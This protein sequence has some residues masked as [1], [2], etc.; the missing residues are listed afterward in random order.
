MRS[1]LILTAVCPE[2][3][4]LARALHLLPHPPPTDLPF[5]RNEHLC[6]A[7]IGIAGFNLHRLPLDNESTKPQLI[8]MAG[9]AGALSPEL[10]RGDVVLDLD[11]RVSPGTAVPG[12]GDTCT[13]AMHGEQCPTPL[14]RGAPGAPFSATVRIGPIHTSSHLITSPAEK[15]RLF[16]ETGCLAVDM[17]SDIARQFAQKHNAAFLAL[18][19]ISD[20]ANESLDPKLL[21]LVDSAGNP[22][23]GR[24]IAML[25]MR[26]WKIVEMIR[27]QSATASAM[28]R[29]AQVLTELIASGWLGNM[30]LRPPPT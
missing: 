29:V 30:P 26:P 28:A 27:L 7:C 3:R 5:W 9:V 24:A 4:A 13:R 6:L 25:T 21:S 23:I 11:S 8:V 12:L 10:R 20:T 16:A 17:E 22:R 2:A 18:R 15:A 1:V 14:P 19:G